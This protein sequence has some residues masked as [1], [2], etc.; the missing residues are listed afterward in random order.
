[1]ISSPLQ[2]GGRVGVVLVTRPPRLSVVL[3]ALQFASILCNETPRH[4]L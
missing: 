3:W 1:V 4:S 2:G